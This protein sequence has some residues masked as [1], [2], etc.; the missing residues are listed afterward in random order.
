M[1]LA[2]DIQELKSRAERLLSADPNAQP[3]QTAGQMRGQGTQG[4]TQGGGYGGQPRRQ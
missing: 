2:A 4:G 1:N 3:A